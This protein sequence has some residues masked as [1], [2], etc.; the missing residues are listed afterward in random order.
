[1]HTLS[2]A[3]ANLKHRQVQ[4][5]ALKGKVGDGEVVGRT[6]VPRNNENQEAVLLASRLPTVKDVKRSYDVSISHDTEA[7]TPSYV[8][9][10]W[11]CFS[12][13]AGLR[14]HHSKAEDSDHGLP[15]Q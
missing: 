7:A 12:F 9:L 8:V 10:C 14:S 1:M 5:S 3:W 6:T 15:N 13:L 4:V 11:S 2:G